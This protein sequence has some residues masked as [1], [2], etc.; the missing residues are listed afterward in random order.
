MLDSVDALV[1]TA[2]DDDAA[3]L[4]NLRAAKRKYSEQLVE[5]SQDPRP[6]YDKDGEQ[7]SWETYQKFLIEQINRLSQAINMMD[8]DEVVSQGFT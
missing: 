4:Q 2:T 7:V 1:S 5:L 6:S 8:P 3:V